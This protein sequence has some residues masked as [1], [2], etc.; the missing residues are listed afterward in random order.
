MKKLS[1]YFWVTPL[2]LLSSWTKA[3]E[4]LE[5]EVEWFAVMLNGSKMGHMRAERLVYDDRVETGTLT[6]LKIERSGFAMEVSFEEKTNETREGKPLGFSSIQKTSGSAMEIRGTIAADGSAK[7]VTQTAG[8]ANEQQ[9]TWPENALLSEGLRLLTLKQG[10]APGTQFQA[11]AFIPSS[12]SAID[13]AMTVKDLETVD[14]FGRELLLHRVEQSMLLSGVN[15]TS[16]AYVT[17]EHSLKKMTMQM[18]GM[19]LEMIACPEAC[20]LSP[21]EPTDFFA[22][23]IATAP[24]KIHVAGLLDGVAYEI[25]ARGGEHDLYFPSSAEQKLDEQDGVFTLTVVPGNP[26]PEDKIGYQGSDPVVLAA[27][28]PTSWIQSDAPELA[29]LAREASSGAESA[30]AA[31]Q[32]LERFVS[33]YVSDKNLS[34]G[35]ASALE[36]SQTRS[37]DCTE[38]ALLLAGLGRALGIPTRVATGMAY[39]EN[40]LGTENAFVPHAWTQAFVGDKWVSYDAALNGF[41]AGHIALSYGD[42]DPWKFYEAANTIGNFDIEGVGYLATD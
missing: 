39:V 23:T 22:A 8:K 12:L 4:P 33:S 31:M 18:M 11:K 6:S 36:V 10:I 34:V 17:D 14:L 21:N 27:L 25:R 28:E 7:V 3:A 32:Q 35:Y 41:D 15:T 2:L 20:A 13:V 40:W 42:G 24:E 29:T 16:V 38:H 1:F 9:F 37:G 5:Q 30:H 19:D 26:H